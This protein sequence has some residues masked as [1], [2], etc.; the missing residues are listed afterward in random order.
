MIAMARRAA[1]VDKNQPEIVEYLRACGFTVQL[2]HA[3]GGGCPDLL[4]GKHGVN[5]L[6]EVKDG[7][8]KLNERQITWHDEWQGQKMVARCIEDL[9]DIL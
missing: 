5:Y 9:E 6:I 7:K 2:L 3:V 1:K 8:G 4:A